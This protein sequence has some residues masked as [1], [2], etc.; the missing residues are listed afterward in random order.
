M[1]FY[2]EISNGFLQ[3]ASE[4]KNR[5]KVLPQLRND[6]IL[7]GQK[8]EQ[9]VNHFPGDE[10]HL[11]ASWKAFEF[12]WSSVV[13]GDHKVSFVLNVVCTYFCVLVCTFFILEYFIIIIDPDFVL[14]ML[15]FYKLPGICIV[16]IK[17][18]PMLTRKG[19]PMP[20]MNYYRRDFGRISKPFDIISYLCGNRRGFKL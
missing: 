18:I 3:I 4:I 11:R 5:L 9:E 16:N 12:F 2:S 10:R 20:L 13:L 8:K 15:F 1:Y 7:T 19:S 6:I 14:I 17:P